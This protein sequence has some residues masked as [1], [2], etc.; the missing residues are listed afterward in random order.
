[1]QNKCIRFCMNLGNRHHI[2]ANDFKEIN[3]LPTKERFEQCVCVSTFKFWKE[4][5]PA[6]MYDIYNKILYTH[7]TRKSYLR[8]EL[9]SINTFSGKKGLSY[10]GPRLWNDLSFDLKGC[11]G[12]NTFKHKVKED[13]FRKLKKKE[14]DIYI[15]Y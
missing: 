8:L 2:S 7:G 11:N 6:Y 4:K 5:S 15:Y 3:W 10:I 9:P 13:F 12:A 14:D 1:M